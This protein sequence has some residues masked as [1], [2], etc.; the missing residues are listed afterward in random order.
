M[1]AY[2]LSKKCLLAL[3]SVEELS[4]K[5]KTSLLSAV[6]D[7]S[8]LVS[9]K[10]VAR[11]VLGEEHCKAFYAALDDVDRQIEKLE[12]EEAEFVCRLDDN[13]PGSLSDIDDAPIGLF[14]KGDLGALD[15]DCIAI[16]GT[17]HPTRY[18]SKVAD[19]FAREFA[20]AGVTV[21]SGFARGVDSISH[22]AC[23]DQGAKTV[24]VWGSGLDVCYPAEHLGLAQSILQNGGLIVSE[25]T[26]GTKPLQYHFPERNRLISGLSRAVFLAEAAAKSGSLITMRLAIEQG[27]DIFTV[28]GNIYSAECEGNNNLLME[29]PHALALSPENVLDALRI[30]RVADEPKQIE[31]SIMENIIVE[32]LKSGEKHFEELLA[33][34]DLTVAELT[35]LLFNLEMNGVVDNIGGNYYDLA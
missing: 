14:V 8:E 21:V 6:G 25:Y 24:A 17:R 28:P 31:L 32:E 27:R 34:T 20:R 18:G 2:D 35:N 1:K 3:A 29:M 22:K 7:A 11:D 9:N 10:K 30:S 12:R 5:K 26:F 33:A 4:N 19:E 23:V 13:F 15:A 16:V